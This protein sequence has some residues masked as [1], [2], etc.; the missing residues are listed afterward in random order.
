VCVLY[1]QHVVKEVELDDGLALDQVVH[2]GRVDV[3]HGVRAHADDQA[4]QQV[5]LLRR[6][7]DTAM[8]RPE[9]SAKIFFRAMFLE[10]KYENIVLPIVHAQ[11]AVFLN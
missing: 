8:I 5:D 1:L 2:H 9:K 4:L 3:R 6:I 11:R 7:Q 10:K